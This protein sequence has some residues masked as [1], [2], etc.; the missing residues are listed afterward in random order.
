MAIVAVEHPGHQTPV[1][2]GISHAR[3]RLGAVGQNR[4][5]AA[6]RTHQIGGHDGQ[7]MIASE[8]QTVDRRQ[9]PAVPQHQFAGY[10]A[11]MQQRARAV[12][13]GQH[14]VQQLGTLPQP[15]LQAG[16]FGARHDERQH[17]DRPGIGQFT[18]TRTAVGD[19]LGANQPGQ[20]ALPP[21]PTRILD[22][23]ETGS[24]SQNVPVGKHMGQLIVATSA[25]HVIAQY[26][27]DALIDG[28]AHASQL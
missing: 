4:P 22:L 12:E 16:P 25:L 10:H 9:E 23:G 11:R 3:R 17:V 14:G 27:A 19:R 5:A 24:E 18:G 13:V 20:R 8:R 6:G 7:L 1:R 26:R 28:L 15:G 21:L 2:H